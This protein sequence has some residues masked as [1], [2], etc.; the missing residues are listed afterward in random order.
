MCDRMVALPEEI[1][2]EIRAPNGKLVVPAAQSGMSSRLATSHPWV[3]PCKKAIHPT[4]D[5]T[6]HGTRGETPIQ[7]MSAFTIASAAVALPARA[8]AS[9][10]RAAA[11][12]ARVNLSGARLA[13]APARAAARRDR[14]AALVVRMATPGSNPNLDRENPELEEK[15]AVIG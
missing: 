12:A 2:I 14:G 8:C 1:E 5:H 9:T 13:S 3:T 11:P 15:F 6:P 7:T 10:R 4:A